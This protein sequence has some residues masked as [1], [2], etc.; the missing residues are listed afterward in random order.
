MKDLNFTYIVA[1]VVFGYIMYLSTEQLALSIILGTGVAF[2]GNTGCI[3]KVNKDKNEGELR[4]DEEDIS[5]N[6]SN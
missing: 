5:A 6:E 4:T 2:G 3:F 1:G